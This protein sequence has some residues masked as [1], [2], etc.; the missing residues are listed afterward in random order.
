MSVLAW[1]V[2]S[3][4]IVPVYD[5]NV[6]PTSSTAVIVTLVGD[7]TAGFGGMVMIKPQRAFSGAASR[8][9]GGVVVVL[10]DVSGAASRVICCHWP[11]GV[12]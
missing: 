11:V 4:N 9:G 1:F 7:P 5:V 6:L 3:R 12:F 8:T 2:R 10:V